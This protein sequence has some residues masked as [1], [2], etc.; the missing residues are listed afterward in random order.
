MRRLMLN[1][2]QSDVG[3]ALG[4]TFQQIQKYEKGTNRI[5]ASRLHQMADVLQVPVPFFFE[6]LA[7]LKL[8]GEANLQAAPFDGIVEFLA[9]RDGLA[10]A[11][12]FVRIA[13]KGVRRQIVGLVED[14]ASHSA[15][16]IKAT[17]A[18]SA[19]SHF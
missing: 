18:P 6:G 17:R 1:M 10:L 15:E 12:A 8:D 9:T 11:K 5:S 4:L 13:K 7:C 19:G 3:E 2:S 16:A 14:L